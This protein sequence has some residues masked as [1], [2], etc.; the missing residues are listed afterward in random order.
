MKYVPGREICKGGNRK[1]IAGQKPVNVGAVTGEF[2]SKHLKECIR[3]RS[4]RVLVAS[5][6]T[7]VL[8]TR[9]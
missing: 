2:P 8:A 6:P 9:S 1:A 7:P 3:K 4:G 5:G